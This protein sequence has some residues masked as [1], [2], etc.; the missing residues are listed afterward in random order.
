M[1]TIAS[2]AVFSR[3]K[4][5]RATRFVQATAMVT[6]PFALQWVLGGY[7]ASSAVSLWAF[8]GAI[9]T[10][11]FFTP[12]ESIPW[13][14][15]FVSLTIVSGLIDPAL[16]PAPIPDSVRLAFFVLNVSGVSLTAYALL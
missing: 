14:G 11:F 12:R 16:N 8:V 7:V 9:G 4:D 2:L 10:M 3:T 1:L 15:G 6:L 13:F 5:Y